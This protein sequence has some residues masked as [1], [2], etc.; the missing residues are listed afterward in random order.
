MGYDVTTT[1]AAL[2]LIGSILPDLV[3]IP[4]G[5]VLIRK[6]GLDPFRK[7]SWSGYRH[8][9]PLLYAIYMMVHSLWLPVWIG[10]IEYL[11]SGSV[12][13]FALGWTIHSVVDFA[14][15]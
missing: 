13:I 6:Y 9:M 12:P 11:V 3:N 4:M 15:H 8:K 1:G 5:I 7:W 10:I 14:T 2:L